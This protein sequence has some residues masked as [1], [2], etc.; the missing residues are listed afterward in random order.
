VYKTDPLLI[1]EVELGLGVAGYINMF[2]LVS[3]LNAS[4]FDCGYRELLN[5]IVEYICIDKRG[6]ML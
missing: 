1:V 4:D 6:V 2:F 3:D 5:A